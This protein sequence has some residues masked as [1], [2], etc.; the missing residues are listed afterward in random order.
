MVA[1]LPPLPGKVLQTWYT[2]LRGDDGDDDA[3]YSA[4]RVLRGL[5][6]IGDEQA[7]RVITTPG[8]VQVG[9]G[10]AHLHYPASAIGHRGGLQQ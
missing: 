6:E 9:L 4:A 7:R 10:V 3:A 2:L 8:F 1:T 5:V